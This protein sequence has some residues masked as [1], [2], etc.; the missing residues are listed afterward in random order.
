MHSPFPYLSRANNHELS[1]HIRVDI[2]TC[3]HEYTHRAVGNVTRF[4]WFTSMTT[5]FNGK[6][7]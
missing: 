6:A 2:H 7:R 1:S 3:I 4:T 5:F